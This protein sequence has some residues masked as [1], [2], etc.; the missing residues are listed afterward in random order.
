MNEESSLQKSK[1]HF[2]IKIKNL[3]SELEPWLKEA[4]KRIFSIAA[5]NR[6]ALIAPE[7]MKIGFGK[8]LYA[9]NE[10]GANIESNKPF[11]LFAP[12]GTCTYNKLRIKRGFTYGCL[13]K[14]ELDGLIVTQNAMPNGCGYSL[15]EFKDP[16]NDEKLINQAKLIQENITKEQAIELGKGNHFIALYYVL[17]S[18]SGED[19]GK[20]YVLLHC[21]GHD[22]KK[23][24]LYNTDWLEKEAGFNK[25]LTPHGEIWLLEDYAKELYLKEYEMFENMNIKGRNNVMKDFFEPE[26]FQ[27]LMDL[28]HQGLVENGKYLKLGVHLKEDIVP[29]AFNADEGTMILKT[30]SNLN[31]EFLRN[32]AYYN[33]IKELG[34]E[35]ELQGINITPHGS[36]YEF[37][38]PISGCSFKLDK[39]GLRDFSISLKRPSGNIEQ[40]NATYFKEIRNFMSYRRKLPIMKEVF[41][42]NLGEPV[43][44]LKPLIQIHPKVSIPGGLY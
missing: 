2:P 18:V 14:A 6:I 1:N 26:S 28:T 11:V 24:P 25:I 5:G 20:R 17:D 40:V 35:R 36:G 39:N 19:T 44:D 13:I 16:P 12:D 41:L 34:Y 23:E 27:L 21:S 8:I 31:K 30:N 29:V 22:V 38:Y 7:I 42:A 43:F 32:W 3:S 4:E 15:F 9:A 33:N 10:L 37:K